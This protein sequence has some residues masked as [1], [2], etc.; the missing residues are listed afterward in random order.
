MTG[1]ERLIIVLDI[2]EPFV[3]SYSHIRAVGYGHSVKAR[4]SGFRHKKERQLGRVFD[5]QTISSAFDTAVRRRFQTETKRHTI[6]L[7]I[8]N[9]VKLMKQV[10]RS[11]VVRRVAANEQCIFIC[12]DLITQLAFCRYRHRKR[13][14]RLNLVYRQLIGIR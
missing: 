13:L 7:V 10:V 5:F 6:F 8:S 4:K 3:T 14:V 2:F 12:T 9:R 1:F 11:C